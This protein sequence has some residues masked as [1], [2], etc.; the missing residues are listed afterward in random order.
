MQVEYVRIY[1]GNFN[2]RIRLKPRKYKIL[3]KTK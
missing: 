1:K 3:F 2:W